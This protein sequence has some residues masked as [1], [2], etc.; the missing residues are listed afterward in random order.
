MGFYRQEYWSGLPFP[1]PGDLPDTGIE[2]Q[3]CG[4]TSVTNWISD[5]VHARVRVCQCVFEYIHSFSGDTS[6]KESASQC[7][8][9][10][11]IFDP[12]VERNPSRK[13]WQPTPV[14]LPVKSHGQ[15]N[16]VGYSPWDRKELGMT[17]QLHFHFHSTIQ[18]Y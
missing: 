3:V 10:R 16:L 1:S 4:F 15:R 12:W 18:K 17:E 6:G 5:L 14:F 9:H 8:R 13:K 11:G 2:T 7:K